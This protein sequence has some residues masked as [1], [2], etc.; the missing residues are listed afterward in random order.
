MWSGELT[1]EQKLNTEV[2]T[3]FP[4]DRGARDLRPGVY[5]MTAAPKEVVTDDYDQ[6]ATQ[7]FIVSDLGLTAY[8][9]QDGIDVFIHSLATAEPRGSVEVRLIA[10]NNEVL[11]TKPTDRNGFV[12]FEAGLAR[13]EGGLS[14]GGD[15]CHATKPTTRS[16]A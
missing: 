4:V 7:W 15:R 11:A 3:A 8:S 1:V 9:G 13:G 14:A 12:H 16:S 5:V 2:T 6:L 10:R